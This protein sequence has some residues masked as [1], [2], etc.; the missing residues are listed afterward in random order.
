MRLS[1]AIPTWC[2][3]G[4]DG[5][6][7]MAVQRFCT[8][9]LSRGGGRGFVSQN[10]GCENEGASN[11]SCSFLV[12]VTG[13]TSLLIFA[14]SFGSPWNVNMVLPSLLE[15]GPTRNSDLYSV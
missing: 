10:V 5:A 11:C 13:T 3:R 15:E 9:Q 12:T 14:M 1:M 2:T 7:V 4:S 8:P 6:F